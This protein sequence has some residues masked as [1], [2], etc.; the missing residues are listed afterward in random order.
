MLLFYAAGANADLPAAANA[1]VEA[2]DGTP[3]I[4]HR[5]LEDARKRT[6]GPILVIDETALPV[7]LNTDKVPRVP[8]IPPEAIQN[9]NPYR[10]PEPVTAAGGFV[11]CAL[12]ND[13]ALLLIY[14][15]G[16]WDLPKGKQDP[17]EDVEACARREVQEELGIDRLEVL[18]SLGTTVHGYA[19]SQ[20]YAVKTTH[21]F[22]M[23][24]T[25]RTFH[26]ERG[27]GI[28]RIH[29]ARWSV[30]YRHLG[31][32]N[33]RRHMRRIEPDVRKAFT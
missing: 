19:N 26:P 17:G 24:T 4:L 3:L 6:D 8:R 23:Q 25:E 2:E 32:E 9:L 20:T 5:A 11:G 30:A 18:G 21:W 33:L 16:V 13:V 12:P 15:R 22:L 28:H 14:R 29:W 1:G 7:P 27:E 10:P 31:Y